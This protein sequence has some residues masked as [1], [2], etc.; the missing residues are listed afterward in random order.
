MCGLTGY[1]HPPGS[2]LDEMTA[3]VSRMNQ[4]L[5]HRGPDGGGI[6]IDESAGVAL[7]HRRLAIVDIS[8]AGHQPMRSA[9][10]RYVIAFNGEIYNHQALRKSLHHVDWRGHSDT[11]T[12]VAGIAQW[13]FAATLA[14]CVG[15]FAIALWDRQEKC[16]YL[17]RDRFGEKP[18]YYGWQNGCFLFGSELKAIKTHP[19]FRAEI[20]RDAITLQL[21]HNHIPAPYSIYRDIHKLPPGTHLKVSL[22][23]ANAAIGPIPYWSFKDVV[24]G[25]QAN[26]FTGSDE[27]A[28]EEVE[29]TLTEAVTQQM[30][31]DVP[32]G[33][34]LSG[35]VDSST[36]VALMQSKSSAPIKTFTIGFNDKSFDEAEHALAVARHLGTDHT[37]LYVSH[38]Q[39]LSVIQK[40]PT[41]YDEPFSDSSQIPTYL[42][43][44]M[45][46]R[47]V[48]VALSGDG[49]DELFGGYNR[50]HI[51]MRLLRKFEW[52]PHS[53]R[54]QIAKQMSAVPPRHW[55][56]LA[57]MM[58]ISEGAEKAR[59]VI[60]I[61]SAPNREA[62]YRRLISHWKTPADVVL[63]T[64]EPPTI[65]TT[66]S[67]WPSVDRFVHRMMALDTMC[68]LPDDILVK[69]DR[70][71]MGVSLETR[72]PMLDHRVVE[73][74]WR[75]PL[76]M[77]IRADQS[78]WVLRQVLYKYVPKHLIERPK[79]GFAVPLHSW[80]RGPLRE[81][82]EALLDEARLR[83]EGFLDP[84]PIRQ[85][86]LEHLS[87]QH[88][89]QYYLWDILM[90][91]AWQENVKGQSS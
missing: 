40:L 48:T 41:L 74:A 53:L 61:V 73:L 88:D 6:W 59:K 83:R 67:A 78:K 14:N 58:G 76:S 29:R 35:G 11:E 46:K 34:F 10:G 28:I 51:A 37:Q 36:I 70:A 42:V 15:M 77:K 22:A 2:S 64:R 8:P 68:Y 49:G 50:Y 21:R 30:I 44:E 5:V 18:I 60:D 85:K 32:L 20:D 4:T 75:L 91:Q 87:G 79:K 55:S 84:A 57:S 7:G 69:V 62:V 31:A 1:L 63:G 12:L 33:A 54:S 47:H 19:S 71:A 56:R 81:W 66:P 24:Q 16:L 17:A 25:G 90:F 89:W 27:A 65:L 72:I 3:H 45:T 52:M 13:G 23:Q 82:A 38:E 9:C 39:A 86:W 26:L 43:A 80:L